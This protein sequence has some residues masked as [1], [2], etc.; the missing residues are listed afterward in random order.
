M[1]FYRDPN[2]KEKFAETRLQDLKGSSCLN[3]ILYL[4]IQYR[5][6]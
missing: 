1:T 3:W 5:Y 4:Y 6:C 2:K